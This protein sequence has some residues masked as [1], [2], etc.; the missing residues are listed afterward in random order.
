MIAAWFLAFLLT[1]ALE[2]PIAVGL[3][4]KAEVPLLRRVA[5]AFFASLATHP[6]VWFVVPTLGLSGGPSVALSEAGACAVE[7]VYYA[8]VFPKLSLARCIA[9]SAFANG[10]SFSAGLVIDRFTGWFTV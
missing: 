7:A 3:S 2:V 8:T 1:E 9:I 10:V 6:V 5:L 4:R